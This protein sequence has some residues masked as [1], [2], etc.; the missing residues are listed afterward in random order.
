MTKKSNTDH[1]LVPK[2]EIKTWDVYNAFLYGNPT[3]T[4]FGML[5][6]RRQTTDPEYREVDPRYRYCAS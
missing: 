3:S 2:I 6:V 1:K 4:V 5:P